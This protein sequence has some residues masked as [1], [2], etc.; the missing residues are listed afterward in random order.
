MGWAASGIRLAAA[1][2][3]LVVAAAA[4]ARTAA[5]VSPATLAPSELAAVS[6]GGDGLGLAVGLGQTFAILFSQPLGLVRNGD[7]I[8]IFTLAPALGDAR[9]TISV[10]AWNNGSPII[11]R[12]RNINSGNSVSIGNL[13]QLGCAQLG[14]CDYVEITTDRAR[15]GAQG[16]VVDYIDVNGEV[17]EITAP[18]PEPA[19]WAMMILGFIGLALRLKRRR[20][21][22]Q[23]YRP[24]FSPSSG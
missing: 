2:A 21:A 6:T 8:T 16:V 22:L 7:N 3:T 9:G 4:Q 15:G 5:F 18:A 19:A 12:T 17:T 10:G 24:G 1:A 23:S 11:L 13:F 20:L 14:G